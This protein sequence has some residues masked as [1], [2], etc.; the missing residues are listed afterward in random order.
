M[1]GAAVGT[2]C[3]RNGVPFAILRSIS[4]DFNNNEFVD[5]MQ[6]RSVAAERSIRAIKEFIRNN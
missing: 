3:Y 5:F 2:V 6:F 4:D 1:E